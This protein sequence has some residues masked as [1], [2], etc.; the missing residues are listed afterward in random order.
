MPEQ[1]LIGFNPMSAANRVAYAKS[2]IRSRVLW[3]IMSI[4]I[5]TVIWMWRRATLTPV[6]TGLLFGIGLTYSV[7]W[8]IIAIMNHSRAKKALAAITP[9]VAAIVDRNGIWL[10]GTGM[11]WTE[12]LKIDIAP[13]KFGGSPSLNVTRA[14]GFV[15]SI[16]VADLDVMPGTIDA[17]VRSYSA[18]T[19]HVDTSTLGN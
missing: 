7:I 5:C 19:Q 17:A 1:L 15:A 3:L 12:I 10:Q 11:A 4:V 18:G 14:D 2:Q 6:Y 16:S 13:G 9:G 8:L